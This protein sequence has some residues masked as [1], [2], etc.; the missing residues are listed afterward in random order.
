MCPCSRIHSSC[1]CWV[2]KEGITIRKYISCAQVRSGQLCF[3]WRLD[4]EHFLGIVLLPNFYSASSVLVLRLLLF[5]LI[6][7][8]ALILPWSVVM[9]TLNSSCDK[10]LNSSARLKYSQPTLCK[11]AI[12]RFVVCQFSHHLRLVRA[13][14]SMSIK[15]TTSTLR[16][17]FLHSLYL[18]RNLSAPAES[19]IL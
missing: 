10:R 13:C 14:E 12:G 5:I 19:F 4:C 7:F 1:S 11:T 15:F 3:M 16:S 6:G 2:G 18:S 9:M 8:E 17:L